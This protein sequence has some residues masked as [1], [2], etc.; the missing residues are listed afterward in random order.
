MPQAVTFILLSLH[1]ML[2]LLKD[3]KLQVQE[4]K[5]ESSLI[6]D[7]HILEAMFLFF[8]TAAHFR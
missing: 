2:H 6:T 8:S 1:L 4:A 3:R 7:T 5:K